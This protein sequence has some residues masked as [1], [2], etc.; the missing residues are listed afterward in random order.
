MDKVHKSIIS[1]IHVFVDMVLDFFPETETSYKH[2]FKH[3]IGKERKFAVTYMDENR[4]FKNGMR[5]I[6]CG[7]LYT[8]PGDIAHQENTEDPT[9]IA[10]RCKA[11]YSFSKWG[12]KG[13][14]EYRRILILT[15]IK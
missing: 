1:F 9:S 13:D 12:W 3:F 10:I 8:Q 11:K 4:K 6:I 2:L 7:K 14:I 5:C 15:R